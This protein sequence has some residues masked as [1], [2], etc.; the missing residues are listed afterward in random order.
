MEGRKSTAAASMHVSLSTMSRK[1]S[2]P[3]WG[4]S[5]LPVSLPSAYPFSLYLGFFFLS[6]EDRYPWGLGE[7]N[8]QDSAG[9]TDFLLVI[10]HAHRQ[11]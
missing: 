9:G 4:M 6:S 11:P 1:A 5:P 8:G 7:E 2:P 10:L 3:G